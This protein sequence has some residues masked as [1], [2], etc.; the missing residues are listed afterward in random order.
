MAV[1]P[2]ILKVMVME[3]MNLLRGAV[4]SVFAN[5]FRRGH[6]ALSTLDA[7]PPPPPLPAG[8]DMERGP[9]TEALPIWASDD[10]RCGR[11]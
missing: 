8:V 9:R 6:S 2:R 7:D 10:P 5:S 1:L 4:G 11:A 3:G